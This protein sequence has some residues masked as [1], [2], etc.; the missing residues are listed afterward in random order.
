[1]MKTI[2][3]LLFILTL[4]CLLLLVAVILLNDRSTTSISVNNINALSG[5]DIYSGDQRK[6][7]DLLQSDKSLVNFFASWCTNCLLEHDVLMRLK[8]SG[9]KIIGI[10]L[11]HDAQDA[12]EW[13]HTHGNPYDHVLITTL[14]DL[15]P[16]G[17]RGLP[18]SLIVGQD[19]SIKRAIIGE[20]PKDFRME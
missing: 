19:G 17:I 13:L 6:V 14:S 15:A 8:E 11:D 4:L 20:L 18:T 9:V 16:L 5:F 3:N 10:N 2:N 12:K 7:Q 1:M